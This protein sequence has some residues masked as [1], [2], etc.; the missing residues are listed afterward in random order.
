MA[1]GGVSRSRE[2]AGCERNRR[3]A[4][5]GTKQTAGSRSASVRSDEKFGLRIG[6]GIFDWPGQFVRPTRAGRSC[7]RSH[8]WFRVDERL[9]RAGYS[10]MGISP[11]RPAAS[12]ELLQQHFPGGASAGSA[13]PVSEPAATAGYGPAAA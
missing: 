12:H 10:G 3:A 8:L 11:A 9:E 1:A 13:G 6:D 7:A 2:F 5:A 4:A